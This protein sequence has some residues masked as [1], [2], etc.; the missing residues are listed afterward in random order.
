[1]PSSLAE[2]ASERQGR[3]RAEADRDGSNRPRRAGRGRAA[4]L[5]PN[6]LPRWRRGSLA[7]RQ[8]VDEGD[9][10]LA[11]MRQERD[12]A[13]AEVRPPSQPGLDAADAAAVRQSESLE[14]TRIAVVPAVAR[15]AS[16]ARQLAESLADV[17]RLV[18]GDPTQAAS[19]PGPVAADSV[20]RAGSVERAEPVESSMVPSGAV[21]RPFRRAPPAAA[22]AGRVAA[23]GLRRLVRS[24]RA[25]GP[26]R[27]DAARRRRLQRDHLL[28][29]PSGVAAAAPASRRRPGG[30]GHADRASSVHVVFDGADTGG[31][32]R[33]PR[34]GPASGQG[35]V[36]PGGRR[37]RRGD[38]RPRRRTRLL[39]S[40]SWWRPMIG[41]SGTRCPGGA[42]T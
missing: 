25:P 7:G 27:R 8:T 13:R 39:A 9:R 6:R 11:A 21:T 19:D 24:R 15:A 14:Q 35:V 20:E 41:G 18:S 17:A 2:L 31:R 22:P 10:R 30:V 4:R 42:P 28:V 1:M 3:R 32:F 29:A 16:A 23:R 36:L 40:R 26:G 37:R 33:P 5:D 38:R 12:A 34:R